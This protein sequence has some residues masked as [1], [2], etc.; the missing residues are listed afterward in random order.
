MFNP[1]CIFSLPLL[2]SFIQNG[3]TYFVRQ[4]FNRAKDAFHGDIKASFLFSQYNNLATAQDHFGAISYDPNRFLYNWEDLSH[5]DRLHFAA[6][7]PAGYKIYA[8][9]FQKD[10]ERLVTD[11]M[12]EKVRF[13]VKGLGWKPDRDEN[14]T[15]NF[16]VQFGELFIRLKYGN[17]E[18]K[19]KFEEI[20]KI[21]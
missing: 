10:W 3:K 9:V 11:R 18:A 21:F 19:V 13:Y 15:T 17:R 16:E 4:I 2:N 7:N 12:R 5:R 14:V 8:N 20:E 1:F 6:S